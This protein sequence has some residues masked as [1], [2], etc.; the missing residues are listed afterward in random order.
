MLAVLLVMDLSLIKFPF[1]GRYQREWMQF[2]YFDLFNHKYKTNV[3]VAPLLTRFCIMQN[4]LLEH[5]CVCL[6]FI[7]N[8]VFEI[9][10]ALGCVTT[11][12]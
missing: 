9:E 12:F 1:A 5:A 2:A 4:S 8:S 11:D 3:N 7:K 10:L 6:C